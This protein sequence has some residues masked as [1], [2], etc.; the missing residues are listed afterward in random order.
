MAV[1]PSR[2]LRSF[3]WKGFFVFLGFA[4]GYAA[5]TWSGALL[6][7][8]ALDWPAESAY[9]LSLFQRALLNY[10]PAYVLVTIA[11]GL[12]LRGR[13]R[14]VALV[15]ALLL[16]IALAVQVRCAVNPYQMYYV[17]ETQMA[18]YC[19]TFPTWRTYI[20]F[21]AASLQPL[22]IAGIV[23]I[24]IFTRRRDAELVATLHRVRANELEERRQRIES[25]I[26]AMQ[27]RVDPD[28]LRAT[29]RAV[30]ERYEA[31]AAEG[32]AMLDRLI[33]DLRHAARHPLAD[34][35]PTGDD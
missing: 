34:A 11:D 30:R 8:K 18:R 29:L 7:D 15:V 13:Q 22:A 3:S 4:S 1:A 24:F 26:E 6:T 12:D 27:A 5:W 16:G 19:T 20:D 23:M 14:T 21:P 33:T 17:Y 25:E 2:L 28:G 31:S 10:F 35:A 32:E 9:F